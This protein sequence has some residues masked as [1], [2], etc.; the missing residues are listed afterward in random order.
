MTQLMIYIIKIYQLTIG[1]ILPK[2]CRFAPSCSQYAIQA[3][4]NHGILKGC[5]LSFYRIIRCHPLCSGGW[6]PIPPKG[7][8]FI[9]ILRCRYSYEDGGNE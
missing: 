8:R 1:R 3:L 5:I 7:L 6:D 9:D 4:Y 2:T